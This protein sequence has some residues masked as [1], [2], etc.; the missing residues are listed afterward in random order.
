MTDT[1]QQRIRAVARVDAA[2]P[3]GPGD[4]TLVPRRRPGHLGPVH[5]MQLV[6]VE[7]ALV[8]VVGTVGRGPVPL[9]VSGA[10]AVVLLAVAL[11]RRKGRWWLE[12]RF[13]VHR[14]RQ[15]R[16][17]RPG[18]RPD[19]RVTALRGLAPGLAVENIA[20]SDGAQVGVARDDAGWY[21]AAVV[22]PTAPLRDDPAAGLPLDLLLDTLI[23]AGQPGVTLQAL[24]FTVPAPGLGVDPSSPV[25]QSHRQL[26]AQ[27]GGVPVPVDRASWLAVRLDA[28]ALAEAGVDDLTEVEQAPQLTAAL[29]RRVAKALRRVALPYQVLDAQG[30][31]AGLARACD[32]EPHPETGAPPGAVE[33]WSTWTSAQLVHRTFWLRDWPSLADAGPLLAALS[34]CPAALNA[35]SLVVTPEEPGGPVDLRCLV[36][37]AAPGPDLPQVC[38]TLVG[39]AEQAGGRLV[40]LDGEHAPAVYA[41]A[42]TG[43]G[44]R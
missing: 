13:M 9:A 1:S 34:T 28:R 16:R 18:P 27:L 29:V 44:A 5:V 8:A 37:V 41:T 12:R 30:L 36:R 21:A 15:R 39:T 19:P 6:L 14:Y 42:P 35:V 3:G 40:P 2:A 10:A 22:V 38:R 33:D 31:L 4:G 20:A 32:L 23:E 43:G 24:T 7:A 11:A 26:I 25:V 17:D